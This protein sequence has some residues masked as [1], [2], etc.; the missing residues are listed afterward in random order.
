M[1]NTDNIIDSIIKIKPYYTKI[2]YQIFGNKV[3]LYIK[4][5]V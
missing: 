5:A 1:C 2:I 4:K 3:F